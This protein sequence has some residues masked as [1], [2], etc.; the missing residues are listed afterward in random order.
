MLKFNHNEFIDDNPVKSFIYL[1][2]I[3]KNLHEYKNAEGARV[4]SDGQTDDLCEPISQRGIILY[5][6]L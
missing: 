3:Y 1:G 5:E 6:P 4:H 2:F